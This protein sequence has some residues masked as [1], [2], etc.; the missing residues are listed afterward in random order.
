MLTDMEHC[1]SNITSRESHWICIN[2]KYDLNN[3]IDFNNIY[4]LCYVH[5]RYGGPFVGG[6][7]GL[8]LLVKQGLT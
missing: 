1:K 5:F 6:Y 7:V 2:M 4:V 3:V 8:N